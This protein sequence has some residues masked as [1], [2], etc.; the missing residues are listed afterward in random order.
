MDKSDCISVNQSG[1]ILTTS[2]EVTPNGGLVGGIPPKCPKN[3]GL[4]TIV[5]CPESVNHSSISIFDP[6]NPITF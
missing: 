4:G 1:Q 5:I 3:S 2:A 6:R